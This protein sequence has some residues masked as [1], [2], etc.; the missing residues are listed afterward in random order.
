[1]TEQHQNTPQQNITLNCSTSDKFLQLPLYRPPSTVAATQ[2]VTADTTW[3]IKQH[4]RNQGRSAAWF[5]ERSCRLN[6]SK[7][8]DI[9]QRKKPVDNHF[10]KRLFGNDS[11]SNSLAPLVHG[12]IYED[13]AACDYV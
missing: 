12:H 1:M 9:V 13:Q 4:T 10:L 5:L 7:F 2:P 8:H 3:Q 11:K 6:A